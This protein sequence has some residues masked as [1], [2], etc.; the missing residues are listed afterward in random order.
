MCIRYS[1]W[2]SVLEYHFVCIMFF[3]YFTLLFTYHSLTR[4]SRLYFLGESERTKY[5]LWEDEGEKSRCDLWF[6]CFYAYDADGLLYE[7]SINSTCECLLDQQAHGLSRPNPSNVL[8][9]RVIRRKTRF[10]FMVGFSATDLS[11]F[12]EPKKKDFLIARV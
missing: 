3:W 6:V 8:Y 5:F 10:F 11:T 2:A 4:Y 9:S 12:I 7:R 1:P